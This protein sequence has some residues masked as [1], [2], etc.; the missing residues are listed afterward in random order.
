MPTRSLHFSSDISIKIF[1]LLFLFVPSLG[2]GQLLFS[3]KNLIIK[4]HAESFSAKPFDVDNDGDLD[5]LA[6]LYLDNL[7][8]WYENLDGNGNFDKQKIISTDHDFPRIIETADLDGDGDE[9]LIVGSND[10]KLVW[11]ENED[12][13]GSFGN[14]QSIA[15]VTYNVISLQA[16]DID[17]D[18][19]KDLLTHT[20][21]DVVWY[22]NEDGSGNFGLEK[23]VSTT[24]LTQIKSVSAGDLDGDDDLD[25]IVAANFSNK[26]GW[27]ENLDGKG[28]F[29]P[30]KTLTQQ[31]DP[32]LA[33]PADIDQDGDLDIIAAANNKLSWY[34]NLN[35]A[36]NFGQLHIV[37]DTAN[38]IE[39]VNI[40]DVDG[41]GDLDLAATTPGNK[42]FSW[43]ENEDGMGNFGAEHLIQDLVNDAKFMVGG[44]FDGDSDMD[45]LASCYFCEDKIVWYEN[46]DG[47]GTF[48][49]LNPIS[50][51]AEGLTHVLLTDINGDGN[52]DVLTTSQND[53]K[54]A[55][56]E[57]TDGAED[58]SKQKIISTEVNGC[59]HAVSADFD[60]DGDLDIVASAT[61]DHQVL[62][63]ENEDGKGEFGGKLIIADTVVQPKFVNATDIDGDGDLDVLVAASGEDKI[64]WYENED[65]EG[66]F[67][68]RQTIA[69]G[70]NGVNIVYT[71][72]LDGDGLK[73]VVSGSLTDYKIYWQKNE[74]GLGSFTVPQLVTDQAKLVYRIEI[75]DLDSDGDLD[76]VC[77]DR[78]DNK[79][80][81]LENVD[82]LGNFGDPIVLFDQS[83]LRVRAHTFDVDSDGDYDII[84]A[85]EGQLY[86]KWLEN[87][88]GHATFG[89][90]LQTSAESS[91][92]MLSDDLD[93]DGDLDLIGTST[94]EVF[95]FE[96]FLGQPVLSGT[97]YF[98]Q[99]EN[100]LRDPN[101][102]G[103]LN[104]PVAI[105]PEAQFSFTNAQGEYKFVVEPGDYTISAQPAFPWQLTND[106][107][108]YDVSLSLQNPLVTDLD[109]GM[110]PVQ[111]IKS[112]SA[113][114]TTATTRCGFQVPFW[115]S[116]E[117]TGTTFFSGY[118][119]LDVDPLTT[120]ISAVPPPDSVEN[121]TLFWRYEDLPP[122]YSK[123][124]DL[125]IQV[126][127]A[128]FIGDTL[129]YS[130]TTYI[131]DGQGVLQENEQKEHYSIISCAFD[132]NDKLVRPEGIQDPKYTLFGEELEYT[133]RF[134]N[135]G[136]DTAFTVRIE[137]QLDTDLDWATFRPIAAS[138]DFETRLY[139]NGLVEFL[140]NNILLPDS[141]VNE[142]ASHGF[143]KYRI[144]HLANL[145]EN[146]EINNTANIFFD[147]NPPIQTNSTLNTLVSELPTG[148]DD[149]I[150]EI[151]VTAYPNPFNE[152]TTI[153]IS[154]LPFNTG[155]NL[156]LHHS[157]GQ[158]VKSFE[159]GGRSSLLISSENLPTGLY[160]YSITGPSGI[161]LARGKLV[162]Q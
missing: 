127:N 149:P 62:W 137:D 88:D 14:Q 121:S 27:Y 134:Q 10:L 118:I 31:N 117:N 82:G 64:L 67:G 59:S 2:F 60:G 3:P 155:M 25:V 138:H 56:Y 7:L 50:V 93:K 11:Y 29:G 92:I 20:G 142:P 131:E 100:K 70:I 110:T 4:G 76:F 161:D 1:L 30:I 129:F 102:I 74:N 15:E 140:F 130:T 122:S 33:L 144:Q 116:F 41:D 22:E 44:D 107:P 68:N 95:W 154:G 123:N 160:I 9:D 61:F 39:F 51:Q 125:I 65:G 90:F 57:N 49:T 78:L 58:F 28:A 157:S 12:G 77:V 146:T 86:L 5:V 133:V 101:E 17:G 111:E 159:L 128:D 75:V 18:G 91:G 136:T 141:T 152:F 40:L 99:N 80:L 153:Q 21:I 52:T 139:D 13:K 16:A 94:D 104:H 63:F 34:E 89:P 97:C 19:D 98:D 36:G 38:F 71:A 151:K 113:T 120:F 143:V 135:T 105:S 158:L 8:V 147:F 47:E 73:D 115:V 83:G 26:M 132:P 66:T 81:W 48:G 87:E 54:V 114:L 96:N 43:F 84:F 23:K 126:P 162:K 72:D 119:A 103:L 108:T 32:R 124:I 45:F 37:S 112:I 53:D 156:Q 46:E 85:I 6:A 106:S 150:R 35:G 79:V 148:V 109:F 55:W 42:T 69:S 24:I 145:P